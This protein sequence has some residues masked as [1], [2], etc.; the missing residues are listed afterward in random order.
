MNV[1]QLHDIGF[2]DNEGRVRETADPTADASF[3]YTYIHSLIINYNKCSCDISK[4]ISKSV[5]ENINMNGKYPSRIA[6][7]CC[8]N[9]RASCLIL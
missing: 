8:S 1:N 9:C 3:S 2:L 5:S 7:L 4:A 6:S